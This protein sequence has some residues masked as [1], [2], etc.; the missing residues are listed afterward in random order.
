PSVVRVIGFA[1][2]ASSS[3]D[4]RAFVNVLVDAVAG[5]FPLVMFLAYLASVGQVFVTFI[6]VTAVGLWMRNFDVP[7]WGASADPLPTSVATLP[8]P[9][10]PANP[11]E[12]DASV[13]QGAAAPATSQQPAAPE[14]EK[15]EAAEQ[16]P[17]DQK[18]ES[19]GSDGV[20]NTPA[21]G[22]ADDSPRFL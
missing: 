13:Q 22:D 18:Q 7:A 17:T 11:A 2:S 20:Q 6:E 3:T 4:Y 14:G 15:S 8:E 21:S 12:N 1:V 10:R 19:A 9:E 16:K 5:I